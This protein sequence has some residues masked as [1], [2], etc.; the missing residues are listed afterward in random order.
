MDPPLC[1]P[2]PTRDSI[3]V[4]PAGAIARPLKILALPRDPNPYQ[5]RLYT[6]IERAGHCVRYAGEMTPSHTLNV[7]MLP[8]ELAACRLLGWRILHIHWVF[9]FRIA[10]GDR[11]EVARRAAQTWFALV[12]AACKVLDVRVVWTM[13]NLLPHQRVFHDDIAARRRLV[14]S[15]DVVFAHSRASLQALEALG[16]RPRRGA[17]VTPGP[18]DPSVD[19]AALRAP[20]AGRSTLKLLFF[21]QVWEYKGVEDLLEALAAIAGEVA[22]W[23][24]VVGHCP[25]PRLARRLRELAARTD[26][27]TLDLVRIPE[28]ELGDLLSDSDVVVLPFRR[29]TTSASALLAL[30]Y[31]RVVILPD[32]PAFA[33]VPRDAAVFYDGSVDGLQRAI[34]KVARA[35]GEW[36][37]QVGSAASD[38][39][40]TL[41][42]AEAAAQTI[43]P[44]A[45]VR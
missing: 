43:E 42:W 19:A 25:D 36:L 17:V 33:E 13:H 8:V 31:G 27:A 2:A 30:G 44:L 12:L 6:E 32:V 37:A 5:R 4:P 29:V 9:F 45:L 10:G 18:V 15:S 38:Y 40:S 41:S 34:V 14:R 1:T 26:R 11:S 3:P 28:D 7:L 24:R 16:V 39:V 22:V 23:L 20:G 35:S 21:G